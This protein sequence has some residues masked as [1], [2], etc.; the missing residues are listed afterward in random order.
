MSSKTMFKKNCYLQVR[1]FF[2]SL[3]SFHGVSRFLK[4]IIKVFIFMNIR[5]IYFILLLL[6]NKHLYIFV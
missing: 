2:V 5:Y 6:Y 1:V 4:D 3:I